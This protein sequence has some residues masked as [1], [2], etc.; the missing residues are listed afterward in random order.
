MAKHTI[1]RRSAA[2]LF[3]RLAAWRL[4][5]IL[6]SLDGAAYATLIHLP[7]LKYDDYSL[8]KRDLIGFG[9]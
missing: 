7:E 5:F 2:A 1:D 8:P 9:T 6:S 3:K 4:K